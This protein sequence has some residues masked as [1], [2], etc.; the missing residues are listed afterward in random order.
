MAKFYKHIFL[1]ENAMAEKY[2]APAKQGP[3]PRIPL[4]DRKTHS[5]RLLSQFDSIW[6]AEEN[7]KNQRAASQI[8]TREGTYL[9]FT[10]AAG[11]DLLTKSLESISKGI[12]LLSIKNEILEDRSVRIKAIVYVP[13]GMEGFFIK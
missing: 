4:R 10:S 9:S 3:Q 5:D 13:N 11:H 2:K 8:A 7:I 1:S 12:R 6:K